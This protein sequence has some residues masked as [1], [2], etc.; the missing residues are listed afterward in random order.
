MT[1]EKRDGRIVNFDDT[2]IT[3]AV[4]KAA[5][6][7]KA[8]VAE[9]ALQKIKK[10]VISKVSKLDEP[11]KIND[12]QDAVEEA[13][14]KY[15]LF[16]VE[17]TYHDY[18]KERDKKRFIQ[19]NV[20]K[21]MEEKYACSHN[22]RQNANIDEFSAGGRIGEAQSTYSTEFALE[23][24]M[25]E[26]FAKNHRSFEGY[27][28]DADKYKVGMHNCAGKNTTLITKD[29]I[30]TFGMFKDGEET[31]VMNMYGDFVPATVH[32]Y[33]RQPMNI[34]TF[35]NRL[36]TKD[37]MFTPDH[38]WILEDGSVT[39]S[40]NIG[41]K[42]FKL[43]RNIVTEKDIKNYREAEMF[44]FG[45]ILG[46][47][48]DKAKDYV[49]IR[50]CSAKMQ[51]KHIFEK[52]GYHPYGTANNGDESFIKKVSVQKQQFL[53]NKMWNILS[54]KDKQF[55]FAGYF[56][57]DGNKTTSNKSITTTDERL[58]LMAKDISCLAGYHISNVSEKIRNTNYK[59]NV[60]FFNIS[61]VVED[62]SPWVVASIKRATNKDY[63]AWCV[64]EPKTHSFMLE[65]GM[66]TGNCLS[67]PFDDLLSNPVTIKAKNDIRPAGSIATGSQ[68]FVVYF[69]TQSMVQFGG[70]AATHIDWTF[71]PLVKKSFF[72][73]YKKH[74]ER[75]TE[76]KLPKEFNNK[77]SIEDK[78]YKETNKQ[79]Y[80]WALEDTKAEAL[81]AMESMLHN[82]NTL[83]SRSGNQLPFTSICYGRCTLPE[84]RLITN[85][86]LDAWENGIG[87]NHLTPIFPCG[88]FQIKKGVNDVPGTPN[89][90]LKLKAIKLTPKRIYPNFSN[91]DWSV[92]VKAF[93]KSQ[94]IKKKTLEKAKSENPEFFR[95]IA[96]LS[97][98]IQE[99]LGFHIVNEEIVMNKHEQ[100]FEYAA[101]MGCR[102]FN[103]FDINFDGIYFE[104][105]LKKTIETKNLPLNYLYSAIQ[106]DGRGN[107]IPITIVLPFLAMRA[108]KKA[109][110]HPEY[111]VDYF[112]DMLE[113]RIGDAKDELLERFKW[114]CAQPADAFKFMYQNNTMK[115]YIPEEGTIS[116]LK[117]GTFAIGQLGL[118]ETLYILIGKDQTTPEGMELAKRIEQLYLDKCNAYKEH[119]K[120]NFGVYYTPAEN[121]CFK[122]MKA[123]QRKYG[124]IEN[125]SAIMG[126]DG[127]LIKK[128]FFTNSMH[129]PVWE[130]ISVF[131]KIDAESQ[132]VP[133]SSAGSITYI[134]IDDNTQ[135]NLKAL[136]QFVDYAMAHDISYFAMNF[137]L[138]ECTDCGSTDIDEET[139]TCRK[140]GSQRINWLR[141]ITGYLNGNYLVSFNDG[142]QQEVAFRKQHSKFTNIKFVAA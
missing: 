66:T 106:K 36:R 126:E 33:G 69:Q 16:E 99:T 89:Y 77:M 103:G 5:K 129:V 25:N 142:K 28:H 80:K 121:L 53:S 20:I 65:G 140:C 119:Y 98:E 133:Y 101:Q 49:Q 114:I 116:A 64:E 44:A 72:K 130:D 40:L 84:G 118:A 10:Y 12:I 73:Y 58:V 68:L 82:L 109:K 61:F 47:G 23:Y 31:E 112:I 7:A 81:Q 54:L 85:A 32:Y 110:D 45:F 78:L 41:D 83:Q 138:N 135:N 100:P 105:L 132:L 60:K 22:E 88:V 107:I 90:D 3:K 52:A 71:V 104:D 19:F 34:I 74:Y 122:S 63:E 57:A 29:G 26:K 125:V 141:R 108:K 79:A 87:E 50:L 62:S 46:D 86:L 139:K 115:G 27:I 76:E 131:D 111:I 9:D 70:V 59:N 18:R 137:K 21:A 42:L 38:R 75:L 92:Q 113:E 97:D 4:M 30:K 11:I 102:T 1:V 2:K 51:Y 124:L 43:K 55:L 35:K 123:F 91:G 95:K 136:E 128:N 117:H 24:M 39:T 17:K 120:L 94:D 127:E 6:A 15:N 134:E 96:S 93:E 67:I 8:E 48:C 14:M 37:V 56:A 13:L